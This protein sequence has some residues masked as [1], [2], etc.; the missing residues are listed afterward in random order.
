VGDA[1]AWRL[2]VSG[3]VARPLA[4]TLA[5]LHAMPQVERAWP[6]R[7]SEGFAV[8]KASWRGVALTELLWRA[9]CDAAAGWLT[10]LPFACG[11]AACFLGGWFS[12]AVIR[13]RGRRWGRRIVGATGLMLAG[14]SIAAVP[15]VDGVTALALLLI[16]TFFGNDLA[17]GPAWAAAADI[18]ERHAGVLSGAMNMMGSFMAAI[19]ALVLGQLLDAHDIITP[20]IILAASYALGT[21]CWIGVDVRKTLGEGSD[22][23]AEWRSATSRETRS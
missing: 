18:G 19:E 6:F 12:D 22:P 13:R 10:S 1:D 16:L 9:G 2:R 21:L 15:W 17:M 4:L 20:F 5:D 8:P 7:C 23:A 11:V 3:A 14:L